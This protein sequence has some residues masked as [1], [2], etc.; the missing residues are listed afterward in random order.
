MSEPNAQTKKRQMMLIGGAVTG[1][2]GLAGAGM[3]LFDSGPAQHREKPKTV[4]ITAP[5]TV[6]D[7]DAWRAQQA[8]KE[9]SNEALIGEVKTQ[10]KAQ[11]EQNKKLAQALEELKANKAAAGSAG[12]ATAA[13][14]APLPSALLKVMISTSR[15]AG[16]ST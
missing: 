2:L 13:P 10:L 12:S 3:F 1:I 5:G 14:A 6:D 11:E 16:T 4:S 8:A 9:K 7:K 15:R